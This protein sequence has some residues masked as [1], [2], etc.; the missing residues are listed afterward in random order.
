LVRSPRLD[1]ILA[2]LLLV[3]AQAPPEPRLRQVSAGL[4]FALAPSP[5]R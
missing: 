1:A 3:V 4:A 5:R 2:C